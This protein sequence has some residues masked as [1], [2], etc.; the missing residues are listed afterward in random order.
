MSGELNGERRERPIR[1]KFDE[2]RTKNQN[3]AWNFVS[4]S[5]RSSKKRKRHTQRSI[6]LW[7]QNRIRKR[8]KT[9]TK[10]ES[11]KLT[12]KNNVDQFTSK[13][14]NTQATIKTVNRKR[15]YRILAICTAKTRKNW[16]LAPFF[17]FFSWFKKKC[18]GGGEVF[19]CRTHS[20]H[21]YRIS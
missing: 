5:N 13:T 9:T 20:C 7:P 12:I 17:N 15:G 1:E 18:G 11:N 16:R 6:A 8:P 4:R 19:K 2:I 21:V 10:T 14:R 3:T